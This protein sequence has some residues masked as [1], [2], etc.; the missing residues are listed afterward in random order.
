LFFY[1]LTPPF[2]KHKKH[3]KQK[4]QAAALRILSKIAEKALKK[5]LKERPYW[6][7]DLGTKAEH[8]IE[9]AVAPVSNRT[10]PTFVNQALH[11]S[12]S[13]DPFSF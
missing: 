3:K 13:P 1:L 12:T 9:L 4:L 10:H 8:E 6:R 11:R 2:H 5:P 7:A